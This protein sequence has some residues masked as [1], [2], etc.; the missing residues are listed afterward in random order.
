MPKVSVCISVFGIKSCIFN[1]DNENL[2]FYDLSQRTDIQ[3]LI[4]DDRSRVTKLLQSVFIS[5]DRSETK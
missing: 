2:N 5:A 4:E 3:S 1:A